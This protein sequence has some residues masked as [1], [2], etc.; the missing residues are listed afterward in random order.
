MARQVLAGQRGRGGG[1]GEGAV[2]DDAE[3]HRAVRAQGG[4]V[5]V[6]LD[7]GGVRCDQPAVPG[8]PH[9]QRAAEADDHVRAP[10]Q[11]RRERG[12]EPTG[13]VQRPGVVVEEALGHRG[14]RE[15]GTA[16][17]GQRP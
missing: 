4:R 16:G 3:V 14:R 10:D 13:D 8:R 5:E 11:L 12:G 6:D 9:V 15:Q 17:P 7:H 1:G 2:A